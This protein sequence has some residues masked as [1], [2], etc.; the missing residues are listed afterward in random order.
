MSATRARAVPLLII[1]CLA[2][3]GA[4]SG[5]GSSTA[6]STQQVSSSGPA[7]SGS[8]AG[9]TTSVDS[10]ESAS[11]D[12]AQAAAILD[13]VEQEMQTGHLR[14]VL[15]RVTRG[16]QDIVTAARG[17]S[18]TGVPATSD[19]HFRNG[20]VA[21][22]FVATLLLQ[23][24]D[25]GTV[26]LDDKVSEYLPDAPHA[27][28]VTLG[29]LAQM[30]SGIPDYVPQPQFVTDLV[31]DPFAAWTPE[32]LLAEIADLPLHFPPGTNWNYS[33]SNYV[34]L[35]LVL[36][37]VTG[38]PVD[39][40][41]TENV[42][43]PLGLDNTVNNGTAVIPDPALHS[44]S[45]ERREL[46]G[47][48]AD[49]P[50]YEES[51]FWNPSWTITRGAVQTTNIYDMAASMAAIGEGTLLSPASHAAQVST[52]LRGFGTTQEGCSCFPQQ[53]GYAYGIGVVT[54]GNW[55]LQNPLF[56]GEA[57]AS[58][59]LASQKIAIG[60]AVTYRPEAFDAQGNYSNQ[61]DVLFRKIGALMAPDDAPPVKS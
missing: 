25:S 28:E 32:Q 4:C 34:I 52:G 29:Q 60:I 1:A 47:V 5:S 45:S 48:P 7:T 19:M 33:H 12:P 15:V 61:A 58:A 36:E 10:T 41:M 18:M 56:S 49:Q 13:L 21:I 38:K 26:S 16:G 31:S 2:L 8:V 3:I 37:K 54:T 46:F 6:T 43:G 30:T 17:E 42:L 20:A 23:L 53:E 51:T 50:F 22:S 27:D 9:A 35:G 40:L 57:G 44:F 59:Y 14:A 11:A 55:L 39:E 24:I